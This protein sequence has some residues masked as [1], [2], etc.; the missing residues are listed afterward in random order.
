M[1]VRPDVDREARDLLA[2]PRAQARQRFGDRVARAFICYEVG[3]LAAFARELDFNA[4]L[5][6]AVRSI[7]KDERAAG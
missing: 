6:S 1:T 2:F 4:R 7:F 5:A 3:D